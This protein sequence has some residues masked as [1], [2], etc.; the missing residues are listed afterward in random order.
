M[1]QQIV[2]ISTLICLFLFFVTVPARAYLIVQ[3]YT[4]LANGDPCQIEG[5]L[6]EDDGTTRSI[7]GSGL[8]ESCSFSGVEANALSEVNMGTGKVAITAESTVSTVASASAS[9]TENLTFNLPDGMETTEVVITMTTTGQASGGLNGGM[10]RLIALSQTEQLSPL[11]LFNSPYTATIV[12]STVEDGDVVQVNAF[13]NGAGLVSQSTTIEL[14]SIINIEVEDGVTFV[15][16]SGITLADNDDDLINDGQDNCLNLANSDQ[17]DTDSD[18][19]GNLCDPD[20]DN[21]GV[22]NFL[23]LANWTPFFG[24]SSNGDFDLNGDGV[25]NFL[26]FAILTSYFQQPPGPSAIAP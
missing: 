23:D 25:L 10:I 11:S 1:K 15:S 5:E 2:F 8:V 19:F 7:I 26:D 4:A 12:S 3:T 16:E 20:F 14:S 24:T 22:V 9:F 17:R 21:N 6:V 18:G 13:L